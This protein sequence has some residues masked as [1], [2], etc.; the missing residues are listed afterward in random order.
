MIKRES[1][2]ELLRLVAMFMILLLHADFWALEAPKAYDISIEPV[3]S[4]AKF[5]IEALT[6]IGVNVFVF[7]SGWYG[8]KPKMIRLGEFLFQIIFFIIIGIAI[9]LCLGHSIPF[10]EIV[11]NILLFDGSLWFVKIYIFLYLLSPILNK[12]VESAPKQDIR[13]L[14][15]IVFA[16]QFIYGWHYRTIEELAD[17]M[18]VLSFITLYLLARYIRLYSAGIIERLSKIFWWGGHILLSLIIATIAYY[19][20]LGDE[21][22]FP[23]KVYSYTSPFVVLSAI[24]FFCAF[25]KMSFQSSKVNGIAKSVFAVYLLHMNSCAIPLYKSLLVNYYNS[26]TFACYCL[27]ALSVS[28]A[29]FV[30]AIIIDKFR[31]VL[32]NCLSK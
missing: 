12:Y 6:V 5:F 4:F 25:A 23:L 2:M 31:I 26:H 16:I 10:K 7:L 27:Y 1:N 20:T 17:G 18:S 28:V 9:A 13:R 32:W 15:I 3:E 14:L 30:I 21:S 11:L 22:L 8:I 24:C 29:I 19:Q